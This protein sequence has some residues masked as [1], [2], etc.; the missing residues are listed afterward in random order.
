MIRDRGNAVL[1]TGE[2]DLVSFGTLFLANPD[3]PQRFAL[4]VPLNQPDIA[5]FYGGSEK[6]YTDYPFWTAAS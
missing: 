3:L 4:N 1:A 6:G 2:A 5:S